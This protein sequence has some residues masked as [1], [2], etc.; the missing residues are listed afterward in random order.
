MVGV[1]GVAGLDAYGLAAGVE[2]LRPPRHIVRGPAVVNLD[3]IKPRLDNEVHVFLV[4][5]R[6]D[7]VAAHRRVAALHTD[8]VVQVG[9]HLETE[10]VAVLHHL[11]HIG[12]LSLVDDRLAGL[13][14]PGAAARLAV[15]AG[16]E[17]GV[18]GRV[19]GS[20]EKQYS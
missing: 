17:G 16:G 5:G 18:G 4:V 12:E 20:S 7:A 8:A 14:V 13:V 10:R 9:A 2:Q 15:R 3:S 19:V 11:L 6:A 1:V